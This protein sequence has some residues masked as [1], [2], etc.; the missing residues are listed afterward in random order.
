MPVSRKPLRTFICAAAAAALGTFG[1]LAQATFYGGDFDPPTILGHFTGSFLLDV[2]GA[3]NNPNGEGSDCT[4]DLIDAVIDTSS[5]FNPGWV[6][7]PHDNIATNIIFDGHLIAFDSILIGLFI[8][9]T[10]G[11]SLFAATN[12]IP[13]TPSLRFTSAN[14]PAGDFLGHQ[15]FIADLECNNANN[16]SVGDNAVYVLRQIPEPGTLAL[17]LGGVGAAWLTRRRKAAS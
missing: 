11:S 4:I 14:P 3:C 13:C 10:E 12:V 6:A 5:T 15:G 8:P 1:T 2:T 16:Q 7:V 9:S 17:I